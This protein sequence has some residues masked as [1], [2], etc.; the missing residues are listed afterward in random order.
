MPTIAPPCTKVNRHKTL[1]A[2]HDQA[3]G[4]NLPA[5][6]PR[7]GLPVVK[8]III[9]P[10]DIIVQR[11]HPLALSVGRRRPAPAAIIGAAPHCRR[12]PSSANS[13]SS[14]AF[15]APNTRV[16]EPK[17]P[18]GALQTPCP[19]LGQPVIE[20]MQQ[21][22][23]NASRPVRAR[24]ATKSTE[25]LCHWFCLTGG[26]WR[27]A[28]RDRRETRPPVAYRNSAR[29]GDCLTIQRRSPS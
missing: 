24:G 26:A 27:V 20:N 28:Q 9:R 17:A 23:R 16:F 1:A 13:A 25:T 19:P 18:M 7:N 2:A 15:R 29:D 3:G 4:P 5:H 6:Q 14:R 8:L 10:V 11:D 12:A 22:K 21:S